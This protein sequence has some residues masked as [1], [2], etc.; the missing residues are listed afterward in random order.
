MRPKRSLGQNFLNN[1]SIVE[2]IIDFAGVDRRDSVLEIGPGRGIMTAALANAAAHV[3]AV[4]K[5]DDLAQQ[6][7]E[8]YAHDPRIRIVHGDVMELDLQTL[9]PAGSK[10]V[11]NLPYNIA[12]AVILRL[13]E[14]PRHYSSITVM[15]QKEVAM[16]ICATNGTPDYAGLSVLAGVNFRTVPGFVVGPGNFSPRPK[17][18]SMVIK[19]TPKEET[20]AAEEL[21]PFKTVVFGA[22][23]QR[24][25]MLRNTWTNLPG[26]SAELLDTLAG[27]AEIDLSRR[28]QDL[29]IEEFK[30][31]SGLYRSME[32]GDAP[33]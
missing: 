8:A 13:I 26:L 20:L 27:Q 30:R 17:V 31:F 24:R 9:A 16:R 1:P 3:A 32:R 23:N 18:D 2:K 28:P 5:D 14:I 22:F 29:T 25:K 11:A 10:L 4:E 21:G 33:L 15:V 12:T 6:L 19:L 7:S